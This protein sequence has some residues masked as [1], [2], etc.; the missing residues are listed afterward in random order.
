[1]GGGY[2]MWGSGTNGVDTLF[3]NWTGRFPF[4]HNRVE[5]QTLTGPTLFHRWDSLSINGNQFDD[6]NYWFGFSLGDESGY[7]R[8][9]DRR[10]WSVV[11]DVRMIGFFHE[12]SYSGTTYPGA[13]SS[14]PRFSEGTFL[15]LPY[16]VAEEIAEPVPEGNLGIA[17]LLVLGCLGVI[18][19]KRTRH[20]GGS[21]AAR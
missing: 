14:N 20:A 13:P 1:M 4:G 18:G 19:G 9:Y 2:Q 17:S 15:I 7:L 16:P 11:A 3:C 21:N 12:I 10:S 6:Y 5:G 8:L